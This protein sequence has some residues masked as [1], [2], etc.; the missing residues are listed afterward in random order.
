M[1]AVT[2]ATGSGHLLWPKGKNIEDIQ[3]D[4]FNAIDHALLICA[5]KENLSPDEMPKRWMWHLDWELEDW[6]KIVQS[7]RDSKYGGKEEQEYDD[8]GEP[9]FEENAFADEIRNG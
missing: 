8:D 6:F 1:V 2:K 3:S 7:R 4:L 5:W 9:L